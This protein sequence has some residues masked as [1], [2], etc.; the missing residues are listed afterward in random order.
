MLP[1]LIARIENGNIVWSD[2]LRIRLH[3]ANGDQLNTWESRFIP[4]S[5]YVKNPRPSNPYDD[6]WLCS[7]KELV[8]ESCIIGVT[9]DHT[10][11]IVFL[12]V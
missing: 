2:R 5:R 3:M 6:L 4:T 1:N 8:L 12:Q 7:S 10:L 9:T 11:D